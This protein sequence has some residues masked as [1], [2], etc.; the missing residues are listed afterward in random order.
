MENKNNQFGGGREKMDTREAISKSCQTDVGA[1]IQAQSSKILAPK[2]R[3]NKQVL[4]S[5]P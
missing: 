2:L 1:Y 5:S 4:N 3:F